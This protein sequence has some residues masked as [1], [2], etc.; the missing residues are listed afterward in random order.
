MIEPMSI[1][2][3]ADDANRRGDLFNRLV[4]DLFHSLGYDPI[5]VNVHKTGREIDLIGQH[6]LEPGRYMRAE[7]KATK[8][9]IG[10]DE[11]NKFVGVLDAERRQLAQKVGPQAAMSGYFVSLSGFKDSA[12]EQEAEFKE[13]RVTFLTG[14][15]VVEELVQSRI[16]VSREKAIDQGSRCLPHDCDLQVHSAELLAHSLGLI[17]AVYYH[18]NKQPTHFALIHADGD[19]LADSLADQVVE[20]AKEVQVK[21]HT[22]RYITPPSGGPS[23]EIM[24]KARQTYFR[25]L[26][27]ACGEIQLDGLPAD[28][29][30][31]SKRLQLENLFVPL[32]V[33]PALQESI[34]Q[35]EEAE[36]QPTLFETLPATSRQP[37][38]RRGRRPT[39]KR[40]YVPANKDETTDVRGKPLDQAREPIGEVLART[41]R[42]G[43]LSSPGGGKS[44][45]LKRLV[46][47]YA[48]PERRGAS[49]DSL[50]ER[51]WLPLFVRCRDL[52][53]SVRNP[54]LKVLM[55]I[56]ERSEM[57]SEL[58]DAFAVLVCDSL[59]N[60]EALLLIDGLDEIASEGDRVAFVSALRTFLGTYATAPLVVT[61]R[62]AGFRAVAGALGAE[63]ERFRLADFDSRDIHL[64]VASWHREVYGDSPMG[65]KAAKEL[66]ET[67]LNNDRIRRLAGNPMLLTTLLLVK[68][69]VGQL[70][71]KRTVLYDKAIEVLLM[72]WN[73]Q[74]HAPIGLDEALPRLEFIAFTM[75]KEGLQNISKTRLQAL[76]KKAREELPEALGYSQFSDTEFIDRVEFRSSLLVQA[77]HTLENGRLIPLYE[78][79]HLTFQEYLV[80]RAIVDGYYPGRKDKDT[81]AG[82]LS[83]YFDKETWREVV[84]LT[85]VLVGREAKGIVTE[86]I[87]RQTPDSKFIKGGNI[88]GLLILQCLLD[89]VQWH[90]RT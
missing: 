32:H 70:P 61:S 14:D 29:Q 1:R 68:R 12:E 4:K 67:I 66:A 7:C 41:Q 84:P 52:G 30:V 51:R 16:I 3:L 76:L 47:A 42:I 63:C 77:G 9:L 28:E 10:G 74:A 23:L 75:M 15:K 43:L 79:R 26:E 65:R 8:E 59:R 50:P 72:T 55:E 86:L 56:A 24:T 34:K 54:I 38:Q 58:A 40:L 2:I 49:E 85:A 73:V 6:R 13:P 31:G 5:R 25:Y 18:Q 83:P 45:L 90:R 81:P 44:T 36:G 48:F 33:V 20:S 89:E 57:D 88:Y 82:V 60:G 37:G 53:A 35:A 21:L 11:I 46:V 69:W 39:T 19:A 27:A 71:T 22:M 87:S 78:F 64:L 80:A 62:E 17:W